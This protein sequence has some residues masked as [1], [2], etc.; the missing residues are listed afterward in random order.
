[1]ASRTGAE[2]EFRAF[3]AGR[4]R[5]LLRTAWLL[6]ADWA[7]AEDLVQTALMR[8]W[9]KWRRLEGTVAAEAYVR[10]VM[11]NAF[12]SGTRRR[13]R[14]EVP[15]ALLPETSSADLTAEADL[16]HV[17]AAAVQALPPR[18][19]AVVALRFFD[20]L[21]EA[22]TAA[23]LGIAVGTVKSQTAKAFATLRRH[24]QLDEMT[25]GAP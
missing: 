4:Q 11:L 24:P 2:D 19:R 5:A 21:T 22:Q 15:T 16:R 17:V 18:Q 12:L 1:V 20:D 23:A 8:T 9:P 10:R 7:L 3:V 25:Q 6:T 13:W 14:G